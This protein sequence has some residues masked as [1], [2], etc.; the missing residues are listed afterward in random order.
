MEAAYQE[1]D[2]ERVVDEDYEKVDDDEEKE[3]EE[4]ASTE[5]LS[6]KREDARLNIY[7]IINFL[8][9]EEIEINAAEA[10]TDNEFLNVE[11]EVAAD[12]GASE[13]VAA[14]T[15]ARA[16]KIEESPRSRAGQNFIGAGGH[17]MGNKGQLRLNLKADKW[18][19]GGDIKT[20]FQVAKVTRPLINVFLK[21]VMLE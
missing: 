20:T 11:I 12:S 15:D 3:E 13:H 18:R 7:E 5:D 14:D 8:D 10:D 16:Y 2:Y 19:K 21:S 17:K 1:D 4:D 9:A 6:A